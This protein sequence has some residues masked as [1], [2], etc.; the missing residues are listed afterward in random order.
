MLNDFEENYL[1]ED[2]DDIS[3][4]EEFARDY[5]NNRSKWQ[6]VKLKKRSVDAGKEVLLMEGAYPDQQTKMLDL[7]NGKQ[8]TVF[9][10]DSGERDMINRAE[11]FYTITKD[12]GTTWS[13]PVGVS[14]DGTW[15]EA[16]AHPCKASISF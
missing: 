5:L 15:D 12:G 2:I 13:R 7:G 1:Y 8:L 4:S 6:P 3:N 9:I 11:L 14:D 10:S 16:P